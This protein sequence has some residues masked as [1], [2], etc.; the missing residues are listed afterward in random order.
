VTYILVASTCLWN[1]V[2]HLC[3]LYIYWLQCW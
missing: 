3:L 2:E 1:T